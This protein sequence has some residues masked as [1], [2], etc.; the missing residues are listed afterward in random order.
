MI[1]ERIKRALGRF[2]AIDST[3]G[4]AGAVVAWRAV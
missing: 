1:V 3:S 2:E 4:L